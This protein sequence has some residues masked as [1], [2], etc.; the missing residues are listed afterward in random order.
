MSIK[1]TKDGVL[2]TVFVKP[3]SATF[4]IQVEGEEITIYST[5]EPTKGKVN[6][7]IIKQLSKRFDAD[8]EMVSGQTSRHKILL[9]KGASK[10][11]I[12]KNL[13]S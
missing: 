4:S 8:V 2:L 3:N 10:T 13:K 6:R 11:Q 9:V 5:E 12:E 7:E 1:E